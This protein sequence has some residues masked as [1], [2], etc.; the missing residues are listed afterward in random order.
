[1]NVLSSELRRLLG[2]GPRV[3][4]LLEREDGSQRLWVEFEISRADPVA[5]HAKF[6]TAHLF[7]PQVQ[8][9]A[10]ISMISPHV[11]SGRRNLA[12]N[13]VL[14]MRHLGMNAFQTV[15]LPTHSGSMVKRLNHLRL[16]SLHLEPIDIEAEVVR[17]LTV[18]Q[19]VLE[20]VEGNIHFAAN[21]MEVLLNV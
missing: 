17:A 6:A 7:Q 16:E 19:P 20:G 1:M 21:V 5:N 15:L 10:F 14:V 13:T 12:A 11:R 2:Y 8:G 4:V 3:D 18:T 9:D